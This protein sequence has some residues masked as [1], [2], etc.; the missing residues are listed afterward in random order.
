IR[1]MRPRSYLVTPHLD[2]AREARLSE[3][4]IMWI[5]MTA[6]EFSAEVLEKLSAASEAGL[7]LF[8]T[9][10]A[11]LGRATHLPE[12]GE[13]ATEPNRQSEFLLGQ[14]P[15]WADIQSNRAIERACDGH[16]W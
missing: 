3:F 12:V 8:K 10:Q 2:L 13:L 1:E 6:E 9:A 15:I 14:E 11:E 4:N 7:K 5:P 16:F